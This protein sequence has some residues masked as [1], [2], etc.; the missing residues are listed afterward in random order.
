MTDDDRKCFKAVFFYLVGHQL[1]QLVHRIIEI[2]RE[3]WRRCRSTDS[4][5]S[6]CVGVFSHLKAHSEAGG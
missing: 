1:V 5:I 3:T 6:L 2:S 4:L